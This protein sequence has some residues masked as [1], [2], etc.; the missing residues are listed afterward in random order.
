MNTNRFD[1]LT[2]AWIA[3]ASRRRTLAGVLAAAIG[4]LGLASAEEAA[5]AKSGKCKKKCGQCN[6]CKKGKCKPLE[7]GTPCTGGNGDCT[8]DRSIEGNGFCAANVILKCFQGACATSGECGAGRHCV[9]CSGSGATT[10][11]PEC[12]T[13]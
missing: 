13:V 8:C 10:C 3:E 12:G 6:F 7:G 5:A 4:A 1:A 11:A 2:K 9:R